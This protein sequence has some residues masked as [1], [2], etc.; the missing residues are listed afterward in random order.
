M[1]DVLKAPLTRE[2]LQSLCDLYNAIDKILDDVGETFDINM[3]ALQELRCMSW[4]LRNIFNLR[5]QKNK[6][7]PINPSP[8]LKQVLPDDPRAWY[9][10]EK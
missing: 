1:P 10:S 3:S 9:Q 4:E 7:N 8:W 6:E 5:P 2:Q